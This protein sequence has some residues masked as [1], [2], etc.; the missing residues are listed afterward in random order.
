MVTNNNNGQG[1]IERNLAMEL[2]R[3]TEAAAMAAAQ[4]LGKGD[5]E[6]VDGA[7]VNA[8]RNVLGFVRMDGI[9]VIG[10]GEKDEAPMLYIGEKI[11]D[12][13]SPEVDIA[14]DP[15]DG[16]TL[17]ARGLSGAIS[18]VALS[19]R[20]T[21]HCPRNLVYMNKIVTS[22]EAKHVIDIEAPTGEN[23]RRVAAAKGKKIS[24]IT[25]V[26]LD[27]P[28]HEQLMKDIRKAGARVKLISDGDIA[29]SIEAALPDTDVDMLMG[30]G[31]TT[32]GVLSAAAIRCIDGCIQGKGWPRDEKERQAAIERGDD[33]KKVYCTEDLISS[34]DV[35]FAATG[36]STGNLLKGV[37]YFSGGATTQSIAM[38]GRS[39][40]LRWIEARHNFSKL[41]K[42]DDTSYVKDRKWS[43]SSDK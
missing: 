43:Q 22:S 16:T 39:G 5:K 6:L 14:V 24:E 30:I 12:G 25:V 32:E 18:V 38:R 29:A 34:D 13:S 20:G 33:L 4:H 9:V 11:G 23:I 41:A 7:A 31:G 8:M 27:R 26:V 19:A 1:I 28:R 40:T 42:L 10:E 17:T 15:V 3:V 2:V 21:M 37:R 35:F 36:V